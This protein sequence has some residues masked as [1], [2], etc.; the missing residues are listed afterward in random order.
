[1][2]PPKMK[3]IK[4]KYNNRP[5]WKYVVASHINDKG[6]AVVVTPVSFGHVHKVISRFRPYE[7]YWQVG[8]QELR[9]CDRNTCVTLAQAKRGVEIQVQHIFETME[10]K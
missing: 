8:T 7:G 1:M 4:T 5:A 6:E 9:Y 3:W 2:K 10:E